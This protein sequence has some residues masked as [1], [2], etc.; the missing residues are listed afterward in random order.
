MVTDPCLMREI[1]FI[2]MISFA[3]RLIYAIRVRE[4]QLRL[5]EMNEDILRVET[6]M[7]KTRGY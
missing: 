6:R 2:F 7:L 4:L 3:Q 1:E 5:T